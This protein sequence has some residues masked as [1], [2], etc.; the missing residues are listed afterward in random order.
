MFLA[1]AADLGDRGLF[2]LRN[3]NQ[4]LSPGLGLGGSEAHFPDSA[5][6]AGFMIIFGLIF[7]VHQ[8]ADQ[9][10]KLALQ[11]RHRGTDGLGI[12]PEAEGEVGNIPGGSVKPLGDAVDFP[13][14]CNLDK[15]RCLQL[16]RPVRHWFAES[17]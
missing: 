14:L 6:E 1:L 8:A 16:L 12:V 2:T 5:I 3:G 17:R 15:S 10:G 9:L 4:A 11:R 7:E 13:G